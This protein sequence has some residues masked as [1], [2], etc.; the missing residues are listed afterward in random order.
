MSC[1]LSRATE[2]TSLPIWYISTPEAAQIVLRVEHALLFEAS[3]CVLN[4]SWIVTIKVLSQSDLGTK[5]MIW[6]L[7]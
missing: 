3:S 2:S 4:C 1:S 5:S 7:M 6:K